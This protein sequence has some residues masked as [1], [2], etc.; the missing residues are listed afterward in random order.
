MWL[1]GICFIPS[2]NKIIAIQSRVLY[3]ETFDVQL[4][5]VTEF[6]Y[7][8]TMNF[9]KTSILVQFLRIFVPN[10]QSTI[11]LAIQF[12]LVT[13]IF[14][15]TGFSIVEIFRCSPREKIRHPYV[16]GHCLN[17]NP[18][19]GI[20]SRVWNVLWDVCILVLPIRSL[21]L[22]KMP[23]NRKIG[24]SAVSATGL[25]WVGRYNIRA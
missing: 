23:L 2:G 11:Y 8:L 9:A 24:I 3:A 20:A 5:N 7:G 22:L 25:L 19:I 6:L 16:P 18:S 15:Y 21:W 10:Q 4:E 12:I 1:L 17:T 13:N 14:F